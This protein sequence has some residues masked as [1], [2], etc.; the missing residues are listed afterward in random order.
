M[1]DPA[2]GADPAVDWTAGRQLGAVDRYRLV[3]ATPGWEARTVAISPTYV[4][5]QVMRE[6]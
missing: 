5:A 3:L 6:L 1:A 4:P 2:F